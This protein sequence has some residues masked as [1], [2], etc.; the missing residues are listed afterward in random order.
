MQDLLI[1]QPANGVVRLRINRPA[2][3]NSLSVELRRQIVAELARLDAD[4][5]VRAVIVAGGEK[6]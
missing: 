3:R 4:K 1:D 2:A 6:V 5:R